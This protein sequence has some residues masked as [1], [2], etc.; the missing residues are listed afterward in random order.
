[1]SCA[2]VVCAECTT[3]LQGR[4]FCAPCLQLRAGPD[5]REIPSTSSAGV[6][7]LLAV[8]VP[9]STAVLFGAVAILGYLLHWLA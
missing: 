2:A 3:R 1:V 7:R 4:N 6:R 9:L 5:H 8:L